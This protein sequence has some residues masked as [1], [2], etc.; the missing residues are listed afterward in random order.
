MMLNYKVFFASDARATRGDG[1]HNGAL[2]GLMA[3]VADVRPTLEILHLLKR[4]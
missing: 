3:M 1:E 2:A 4:A